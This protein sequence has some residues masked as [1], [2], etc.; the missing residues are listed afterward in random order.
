MKNF[1]QPG[2]K[3]TVAAPAAIA[4]GDGVLIADLFGVACGDAASGAD[5]VIA[6]TGVYEMPKES[7]EAISVGDAVYWDTAES[8]VTIDGT[9]N[10]AI[11]HAV[12]AAANPSATVR[13]R[14]SV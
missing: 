11:G 9:G 3:L 14:L 7:T 2:D 13:V 4:S 6:T 12:S 5:V 1:V 10:T 8:R